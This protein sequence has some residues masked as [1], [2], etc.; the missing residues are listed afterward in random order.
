V[1]QGRKF[2]P[3]G[4]YVRRWVPEIAGLDDDAIHDPA[5]CPA[6]ELR[7]AGIVLGTTYPKPLISLDR[8]RERALA[9]LASLRSTGDQDA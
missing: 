9:A 1:T 7:D 5:A 6:D 2:D 4:L 3:R 8:G